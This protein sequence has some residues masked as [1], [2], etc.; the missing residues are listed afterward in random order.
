MTHVICEAMQESIR[1]NVTG[2]VGWWVHV[3]SEYACASQ[4]PHHGYDV[5]NISN[6]GVEQVE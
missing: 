4:Y 5:P 1:E 6:P 3:R 2:C